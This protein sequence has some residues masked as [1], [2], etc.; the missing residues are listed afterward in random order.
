MSTK[1]YSNLAKYYD[2][3]YSHKDYQ[4]DA[5]YQQQLFAKY[6]KSIGKE[7]LEVACGTGNYLQFYERK[8]NATGIDLNPGMIAEA[9]KRLKKTD[10]KVGDMRTFKLNKQY[11]VIT[12][13]F[14]SIAYMR[15]AKD[16]Q[17][18]IQNFSNH[19]KPGGVIII[20]PWLAKS[21]YKVGKIS[22]NTY[23]DDKI[24]LVR[25]STHKLIQPN[26]SVIE[27]TWLVGK[28]NKEVEIISND[29]HELVMHS[30]ADYLDAMKKAGLKGLF[31]NR[32]PEGRGLYVVTK[33][34]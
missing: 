27:W 21:K 4:T 32:T 17:K 26:I 23:A 20:S 5:N 8:F 33:P 18:T 29:R 34:L 3:I 19:L 1:L 13:L 30:K 16:L 6:Q 12:C 24:S 2:L 10:L 25:M 7:L 9:K 31:I 11:D 14:S 22:M 28:P 15:N